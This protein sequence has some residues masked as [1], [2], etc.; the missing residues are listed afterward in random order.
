MPHI[1]YIN[2]NKPP[3]SAIPVS[4]FPDSGDLS[5]LFSDYE[6]MY[7][8][9]FLSNLQTKFRNGHFNLEYKPIT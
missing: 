4:W 2:F 8:Y 1:N 7:D 5:E 9:I 6:I 3:S